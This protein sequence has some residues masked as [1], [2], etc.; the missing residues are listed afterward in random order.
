MQNSTPASS[1]GQEAAL[2]NLVSDLRSV[3]RRL[4]TSEKF[5]RVGSLAGTLAVLLQFYQSGGQVGPRKLRR[6]LRSVA[7]AA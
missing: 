4:T 5:S 1:I 6:F 2:Q 3:R 7:E